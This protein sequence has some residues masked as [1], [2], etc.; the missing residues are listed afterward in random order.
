[1]LVW[2]TASG[3]GLAK[4]HY[5]SPQPSRDAIALKGLAML[6]LERER[7]ANQLTAYVVNVLAKS[8]TEDRHRWSRRLLGMALT[9]HPQNPRARRTDLHLA[10]GLALHPIAMDWEVDV[11][12]KY[13]YQRAQQLLKAEHTNAPENAQLA[14]YL[15]AL[16]ARV[17]PYFEDA[18]YAHEL[19]RVDGQ[20][21]DWQVITG[22]ATH[23]NPTTHD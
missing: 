11:L 17:D 6:P 16:A 2:L 9:L 5:Q 4:E 23:A 14:R 10:R 12:A 20:A 13:L 3:A 19:N 18:V 7:L 8:N 21:P 22:D 15:V 1:M